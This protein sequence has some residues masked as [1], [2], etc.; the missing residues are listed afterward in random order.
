MLHFSP[1]PAPPTARP[2]ARLC[3]GPAQP[4]KGALSSPSRASVV[5]LQNDVARLRAREWQRD[6][7]KEARVAAGEAERFAA[8]GR[9]AETAREAKW[10][11]A[12]ADEVAGVEGL[13]AR[14]QS[15]EAEI[16]D[17]LAR[18]DPQCSASSASRIDAFAATDVDDEALIGDDDDDC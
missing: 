10:E 8:S 18:F 14:L 13:A 11:A 4:P 5:R 2:P 3:Q 6:L 7:E 15:Y 9:G 16:D 17:V 12:V 1:A